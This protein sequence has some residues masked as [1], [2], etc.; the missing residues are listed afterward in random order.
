MM[1][2]P[3]YVKAIAFGAGVPYSVKPA[4]ATTASAP[5]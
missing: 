3:E 5:S 4:S 2:L 1:C